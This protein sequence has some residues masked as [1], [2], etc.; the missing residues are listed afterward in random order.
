MNI[1]MKCC[2]PE[3]TS[4]TSRPNFKQ[5]SKYKRKSCRNHT[6]RQNG[7]GNHNSRAGCQRKTKQC[8]ENS[9]GKCFSYMN[10]IPSQSSHKIGDYNKDIF[11][12]A[13]SQKTNPSSRRFHVF[14][15]NVGHSSHCLSSFPSCPLP[16]FYFTT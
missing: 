4:F 1:H 10:I 9:G 16:S 12:L 2:S 5:L 3:I 14:F 8:L 6:Q 7:T 15:P 13:R 11:K